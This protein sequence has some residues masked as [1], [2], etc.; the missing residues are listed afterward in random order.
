MTEAWLQVSGILTKAELTP[1]EITGVDGMVS[2]AIDLVNMEWV[3]KPVRNIFD[4]APN[5]VG[6]EVRLTIEVIE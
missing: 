4:K 5:D 2:F 1:P 3:M 6:P